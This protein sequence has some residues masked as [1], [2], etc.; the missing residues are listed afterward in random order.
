M[1][2]CVG[3]FVVWGQSKTISFCTDGPDTLA[4]VALPRDRCGMASYQ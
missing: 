3:G 4:V 1:N 2:V